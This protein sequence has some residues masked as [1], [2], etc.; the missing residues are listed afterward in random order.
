MRLNLSKS[1]LSQ[2]Q[3]AGRRRRPA[4]LLSKISLGQLLQSVLEIGQLNSF[5]HVPRL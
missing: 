3:K 5:H 4:F 1:L 2:K